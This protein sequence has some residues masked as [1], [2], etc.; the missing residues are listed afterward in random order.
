[1]TKKKVLLLTDFSLVKTG[2][3]RSAK[4][5]LSYLYKTGKYDLVHLCVGMNEAAPELKKTPWKSI[6]TIPSSPD[7][8]AEVNRDPK[9]QKTVHYG[10]FVLDEII[11]REKPDIFIGAQDIWGLDFAVSKHWFEKIN[12]AVWTTLDSLPLLPTAVELAPEIKNFWMWSSFA[13]KEMHRLGHRHVR[14]VHGIIDTHNF[15]R[16]PDEER[17]ILRQKNNIPEDCYVIGYVF[18]NQLRKSAPNLIEGFKIFRNKNPKIKNAKLLLHTSFAEGWDLKAL[19]DEYKVDWNDILTTVVCGKCG[20]YEVKT[21]SKPNDKCRFCLTPNSVNTT[22]VGQGVSELELN[23]VYNLMD[24]YCHPFTSG[25]QEIPI[26]EA[27]LTELITLV[28]DYSCGEE[29][30]EPAANSLSLNWSEYR[31]FG[32]QFIKATT[33]PKHIAER[34]QEVYKLS[35][36]KKD[37]MGK[38]ARKWAL[39][40][41]SV[42]SVGKKIE[43]FLDSCKE[44][45]KNNYPKTEKKDPHAEIPTCTNATEWLK[46][47][48]KNILKTKV[49]SKDEGLIHWLNK[50]AEGMPQSQIEQYFREVASSDNL[51]SV[52]KSLIELLSDNK[53][54]ILY[55]MPEGELDLFVSTSLFSSI[56]ELYPDHDLYVACQPALKSFI[57]GDDNVHK[58]LDWNNE[59]NN[60]SG[61]K[62]ENGVDLFEVVYTPSLNKN[63]FKQICKTNN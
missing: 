5:L 48:Y 24:V 37:K 62:D 1:V 55:L 2:F 41:F 8:M 17:K 27:K 21:F 18:R 35:D 63:N 4:A 9:L 42:E 56:K 22:G 57:F 52:K 23:E 49:T 26:Q 11:E 30:C 50:L 59:F 61:I 15:K 6:G 25:G 16:L 20:K 3:A 60:V 58:V 51:N 43:N 33:D 39:Q 13:T 36:H 54:R 10:S 40:N 44:V 32:T 14:T 34:L 19:A 7:K 31:E 12:S 46:L 47:L 45:D 38:A 53:K 28:T 29:M